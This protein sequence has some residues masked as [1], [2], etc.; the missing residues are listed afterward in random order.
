MTKLAQIARDDGTSASRVVDALVLA[1]ATRRFE[2]RLGRAL[3]GARESI[4]KAR[5]V[6]RRAKRGAP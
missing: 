1:E 5:T 6:E 3:D 4:R 2:T